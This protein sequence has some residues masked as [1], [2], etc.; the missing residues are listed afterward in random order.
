[1]KHTI[2]LAGALLAILF[3]FPALAQD[4]I[5]TKDGKE[6]TGSVK[7]ITPT[8]IKYVDGK[9][10]HG[11]ITTISAEDVDYIIYENGDKEV[12]RSNN[13][14]ESGI[15]ANM[16]VK[17]REDAQDNYF[18][19]N[20]GKGGTMATVIVAGDIIGLIPAIACA[21]TT[22]KRENLNY[23]SEKLMRNKEY[24]TSYKHEAHKIKRNKVWNGYLVGALVNVA[25]YLLFFLLW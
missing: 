23:P 6:I 9:S 1:M 24:S 16:A 12:V 11:E 25:V 14:T 5:V 4:K 7:R 13:E 10:F 15:E 8:K 18:G 21:S 2:K 22:P 17:G 20:S 19:D 3:T